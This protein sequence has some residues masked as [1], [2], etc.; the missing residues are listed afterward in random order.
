MDVK[1]SDN[2][3]KVA[4]KM[5]EQQA[6]AQMRANPIRVTLPIQGKRLTF[7][8]ELQIHPNTEMTVEFKTS[9][10]R[11]IGFFV[12]VAAAIGLGLVFWG[13]IKAGFGR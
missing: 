4:D 13:T 9:S 11:L 2:L 1:D 5:L 6:A 7:Y 12:S 8:R 3:N 10:Q